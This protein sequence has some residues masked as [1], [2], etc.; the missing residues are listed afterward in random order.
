MPGLVSTLFHHMYSAP[1]RSVQTFLQA[2]LH[3]WQP[4]HLS[5]W[6]TIDTCERIFMISPLILRCARELTNQHEGIPVDACRSPIIHAVGEL[7]VAA[8]HQDRF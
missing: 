3:V 5:R 6:K 2:T 4:I 8:H 7:T 1:F